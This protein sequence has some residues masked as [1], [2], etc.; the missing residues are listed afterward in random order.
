MADE[1]ERWRSRRIHRA[2]YRAQKGRLRNPTVP[3]RQRLTPR[4]SPIA[5]KNHRKKQ[6]KP[7]KV[8]KGPQRADHLQMEPN[9]L[10]GSR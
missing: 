4:A 6:K 9:V 2:Q 3:Q 5:A 1:S 10:L 7:G 8:A